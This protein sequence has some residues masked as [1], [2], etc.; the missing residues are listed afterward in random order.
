MIG[1]CKGEI[2]VKEVT[3]TIYLCLWVSM[4]IY[5]HIGALV[6][7]CNMLDLLVYKPVNPDQSSQFTNCKTHGEWSWSCNEK[8][9]KRAVFNYCSDFKTILNDTLFALV[10]L[11]FLSGFSYNKI[12]TE[13]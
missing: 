1:G 7:G 12:V 8:N 6:G 5:E 10:S 9:T 11:A 4:S 13:E 2:E 3:N